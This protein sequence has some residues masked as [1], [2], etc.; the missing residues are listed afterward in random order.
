MCIYTL[1]K[2]VTGKIAVEKRGKY[3]YFRSFTAISLFSISKILFLCQAYI[4]HIRSASLDLEVYKK[5]K[6]T[7]FLSLL[8]ELKRN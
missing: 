6:N 1:Q 3:K 5:R 4:V 8:L 7:T 2:L